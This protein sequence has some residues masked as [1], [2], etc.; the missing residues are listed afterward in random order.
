MNKNSIFWGLVL[1]GGGV[2]VILFALGVG[3]SS[4]LFRSIASLILAAIGISCLIK[5]YFVPGLMA[6]AAIVYLWRDWVGIPDVELW[7]LLLGSAL[8]GV[9]LSM[10]FWNAKRKRI[11][12][13]GEGC[14]HH[15]HRVHVNIADNGEASEENGEFVTVEA[16]FSENVKYIRSDNFKGANIHAK[17]GAAKVYFEGCTVSP[18]GATI[19]L[20]VNFAGVEIYLPRSWNIDNKI[21]AF[22]GAADGVTSMSGEGP[23]VTLTGEINFG[24]VEIKYI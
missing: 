22:F 6:P 1:L 9:G 10:I 23:K 12:S 8:L 21:R 7:Q 13:W 20:D 5:L 14:G 4:D 17:F 2:L 24:G 15:H 19:H 3:E 11:K 16:T 18:E